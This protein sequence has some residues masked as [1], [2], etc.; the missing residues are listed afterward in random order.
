MFHLF[1]PGNASS[2]AAALAVVPTPVPT[3]G[4][5]RGRVPRRHARG[6]GRRRRREDGHCDFL[7]SLGLE[8][9]YVSVCVFGGVV[10]YDLYKDFWHLKEFPIS[11]FVVVLHDVTTSYDYHMENINT[12]AIMS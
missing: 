2:A 6:A 8:N 3:A 12:Y 9:N 1:P 4:R 10:Y 7:R 11:T 5:S